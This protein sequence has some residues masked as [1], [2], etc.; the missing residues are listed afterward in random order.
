[1][2]QT[3]K[4]LTP[5]VQGA[6]REEMTVRK[7]N[8]VFILLPMGSQFDHLIKQ[9]L[10]KLGVFCL[11]ADPGSIKADDIERL[12]PKGIVISGG[13]SSVVTEPPPF[14]E[15][16]F[17]IGIPVLGICLGFQMWTKHIGA[18][19]TPASRNDRREYNQHPI[20]VPREDLLF[21][22]IRSERNSVITELS[23]LQSHGDRIE[24]CPEITILAE[25]DNSPVTAARGAGQFSHLWGVQ[26]HPEQDTPCGP[27][28][29]ENFCRGIC[30]AKDRF[31]SEDIA[32]TKIRDLREKVG[33]KKVL[34]A[35]SGGSDSSITAYLLKGAGLAGQTRAIYI[36][37]IDRPDDEAYVRKHFGW[38][39]VKFVDATSDFI[40]AL[41]GKRT[42][43]AKRRTMRRVYKRILERE[44]K[45][46]GAS[47]IAQGTLYTDITESGGGYASAARK[48]KLKQHHNVNLGFS[49]GELTPLSDMVKDNARDLGRSIG[50]PEELLVR[51][52][53]PGPGLIVRIGGE[54][55]RR[56]LLMARQLDGI[57]IEELRCADLYRSVWQA[58]VNITEAQHT[59]TGG[60]DAG[61]GPVIMYWGVWSTNGFTA[62]AAR[63]PNEFHERLTRRF[64]NEVLGIG[65]VVYRTSG[66]PRSTIEAG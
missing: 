40:R 1:M 25:S 49:M 64:Q 5:A 63:F 56:K 32:A 15:K 18:R 54:I 60:D 6:I 29:F 50:V 42:M 14:D 7:T 55:T 8:E 23:V 21:A 48:A 62:Q 37:G 43:P 9:Q 61:I 2:I 66:K 26:F 39:E 11:V 19:V 57:Y 33:D 58:G 31:P 41:R 16:I 52:P 34:L 46:F 27:K 38:L 4:R 35:L 10:D 59:W 24:P 45:R 28:I 17:D 22:D 51:H 20:K 47:Y 3:L 44:A 13:P 53:F 65:A 12:K 36:K 30:Q